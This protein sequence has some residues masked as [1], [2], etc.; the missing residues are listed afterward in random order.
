M[1]RAVARIAPDANLR[2]VAQKLTA[3]GGGALAVGSMASV[4][5]IVSERDVTRAYGRND[6]PGSITAGD[7]AAT[8]VLW[9]GPDATAEEA[10]R[11][12]R[13]HGVRHLL[14]GDSEGADVAGVISARDLIAA[15]LG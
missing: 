12:M 3:V 7:I 15:L 2:E 9:C 13:D 14:V 1:T 6:D 5:G 10:A 8:D 4:V 11:L